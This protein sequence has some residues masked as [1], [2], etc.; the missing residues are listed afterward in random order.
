MPFGPAEKTAVLLHIRGNLPLPEEQIQWAVEAGFATRS[1]DRSI[2]S[3]T[4][5]GERVLNG[6]RRVDG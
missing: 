4:R 6:E 2:P 1:I 5:E 3:L